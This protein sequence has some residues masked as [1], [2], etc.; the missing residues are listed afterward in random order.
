MTKLSKLAIHA[1]ALIGALPC[2]LAAK[3]YNVLLICV[4]DLR[5]EMG[6]YGSTALQTPNMDR[7]ADQGMLFERAYCQESICHASRAS[8]FT[9][10][11]PEPHDGYNFRTPV[12]K[13]LPGVVNLPAL[14]KNNGYHTVGINKTYHHFWMELDNW[15]ENHLSPTP[16][17]DWRNYVT[18]ENQSIQQR[19]LAEDRALNGAQSRFGP[20]NLPAAKAIEIAPDELAHQYIDSDGTALAVRKIR[21][22][23][24]RPFFIAMGYRRPHL[25][26]NAPKRFFDKFPLEEIGVP[27]NH[28]PPDGASPHAFMDS[29]ELRAYSDIPDSGPVAPSELR[30]KE[31]LQAYYASV[32]YIDDLIGQLINE[33]EAQHLADSTIILLWG[34]HGFKLGEHAEW[35]KHAN[36][37]VDLKAP[38]II[39]VPGMDGSR[40]SRALVEFVDIYPT[41][42]ELCG[43][44][45]PV[46]LEGKSLVPLLN[47]QRVTH[48]EIAFSRYPRN[49]RVVGHSI[50]NDQFRYTRWIDQLTGEVVGRELFDHRVDPDENSSLANHPDLQQV[51]ASMDLQIGEK[52]GQIRQQRH[53]SPSP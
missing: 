31:L 8:F 50:K 43:L 12:E 46:H 10:M 47:G 13:G 3:P 26:F 52:L 25:P 4:D 41:L 53:S 34:D 14:F 49:D 24:D 22:L 29:F 36:F 37:E 1:I 15:T 35:G 27:D 45:A 39:S 51:V 33:L 19:L 38:L 30:M 7:L 2:V 32:A 28:Y 48:R 20:D 40:R 6:C 9:G 16:G 21:E 23:K 5:P 17:S 42:V 18:E 44:Q 11:Y